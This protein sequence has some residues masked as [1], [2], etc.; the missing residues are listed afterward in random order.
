MRIRRYERADSEQLRGIFTNAIL[1]TARGGY[2]EEQV[3]TWA[4]QAAEAHEFDER[5]ADGRLLLVAVDEQNK[6]IAYGDLEQDGHIDHLF[7]HPEAGRKGV[8]SALYDELEKAAAAWKLQ[9]LYVEASE[10]ARPFFARKGF[11]LIR[12]N[13][14]ELEGTPIHNYMMEK[15]LAY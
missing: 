7:C 13:D 11:T 10:I 2:S 6:P 8:A 15:F 9:R 3:R 12:R 14:F 4:A 5:A 1:Q